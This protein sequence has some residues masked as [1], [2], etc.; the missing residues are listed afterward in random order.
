M[1]RRHSHTRAVTELQ[2]QP[3][4]LCPQMCPQSSGAEGRATAG[5]AGVF[6]RMLVVC[7]AQDRASQPS[8]RM[9]AGLF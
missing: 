2:R 6:T 7:L 8:S 3:V 9:R 5:T 4:Q 1:G